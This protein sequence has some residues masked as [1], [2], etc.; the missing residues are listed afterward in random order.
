LITL[1]AFSQTIFDYILSEMERTR[2]L[3]LLLHGHLLS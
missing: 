1:V 3:H 2:T